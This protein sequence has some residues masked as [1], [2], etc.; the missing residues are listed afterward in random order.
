MARM[1]ACMGA[2]GACM[3]AGGMHAVCDGR[4]GPTH[5]HPCMRPRAGAVPMQVPIMLR[6]SFCSLNE[7]TDKELTELGEDPYDSVGAPAWRCAWLRG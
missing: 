4:A 5:A 6:S 3:Q 2:V 7:H 1:H